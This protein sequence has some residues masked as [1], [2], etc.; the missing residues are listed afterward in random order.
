MVDA[1]GGSSLAYNGELYNYV[2]LRAE[3]RARSATRS[4][5]A[6]D[7]EVVLA[8]YARVGRGVR[9]ALRRH[10]G[11]RDPRRA[12][13]GA[14]ALAA[15]ASASSRS[16]T[17]GR[18][19]RSRFASEIK[20]LLAAMA[21]ARARRGRRRAASCSR[22]RTPDRETFFHGHP[23]AAAGATSLDG[24]ARRPARAAPPLLGAPPD[25]A[26]ARRRRRGGAVRRAVRG[27]VRIHTR[28]DVPVGTCLSG[29][30]DSSSIVCTAAALQAR[31]PA[32]RELRAIRRSATC[33]RTRRSPSAAAW[34][35]SSTRTGVDA[36]EVASDA[37]AVRRRA[38]DDRAPAGRAVRVDQ[39]RGAVVRVRGGAAR[40]GMKVM[41]D[42]Q[43]A[44]EVLGGYHGLPARSIAAGMLSERR[45]LAYAR[46][47][48]R[49]SAPARR[50]AAA[51]RD[52]L[53]G[54]LP[55]RRRRGRRRRPTARRPAGRLPACSPSR[56]ERD[57]PAGG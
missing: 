56:C 39:H 3:L 7:T 8:A 49:S 15:T 37:G 31:R 9:R 28:S 48:A 40:P 23:A 19:R 46:L 6:G 47:G 51:G 54:V 45:P 38:G 25:A 41:L 44:D 17:R 21:D 34:T 42:G 22:A 2:E 5:T 1:S 29:G 36:D 10:V 16:S 33:R 55:V 30:L 11:V 14:R 50:V 24:R 57:V 26:T 52:A 32:A 13:A 43:G 27:R 20:A 18:R 35:W 53:T 4:A 12:S